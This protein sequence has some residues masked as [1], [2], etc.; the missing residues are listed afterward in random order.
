[1]C[2][3]AP[4]QRRAGSIESAVLRRPR[5]RTGCRLRWQTAPGELPSPVD[6]VA[7]VR[8]SSSRALR[9]ND[10]GVHVRG[11]LRR[12]SRARRECQGRHTGLSGGAQWPL[13][14]S[15][16][17][18]RISGGRLQ[19]FRLVDAKAASSRQRAILW[20][21]DAASSREKASPSNKSAACRDGDD[22]F[23]RRR[24]AS[25]DHEAESLG[26]SLRL[27]DGR[28]SR[29]RRAVPERFG[30]ADGRIRPDRGR[31]EFASLRGGARAAPRGHGARHRNRCT[32]SWTS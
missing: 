11:R 25:R 3:R 16:G 17:G 13:L 30:R 24:A 8:V 32:P 14:P 23:V 9:R 15:V 7:D 18:R 27:H 31:A 20:R 28:R 21:R 12:L 10:A 1:M 29:R 5:C 4:S 26:G 19:F 6:A 2:Q 22:A